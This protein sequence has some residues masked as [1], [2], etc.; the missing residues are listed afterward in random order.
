G[1]QAAK[2]GLGLPFP[3]PFPFQ[4]GNLFDHLL[5]EP[6]VVHRLTDALLPS[7]RYADL[8]LLAGVAL[9]QIQGLVQFASGAAAIGFAALARALGQGAAEEP[10]AGSELSDAGAEAPLGG[11]ELGA[12]GT[13]RSKQKQIQR[14]GMTRK[15]GCGIAALPCQASIEMSPSPPR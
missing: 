9:N 4:F 10:L 13:I 6:I 3:E 8:A 2:N 11:G 7:L 5:H 1:D 12:A 15:V 14:F